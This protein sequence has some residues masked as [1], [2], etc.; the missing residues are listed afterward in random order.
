MRN[1]PNKILMSTILSLSM[2][3]SGAAAQVSSGGVYT[4]NQTAIAGGGG[5]SGDSPGSNYRVEGTAGQS[6]AGTVAGAGPYAVRNGFWI[7]NSLSPTVASVTVTGRVL[8]ADGRGIRGAMLAL[9]D[10]NGNVRQST[11]S[12]FGYYRFIDVSAGETYVLSIRAKRFQ[13]GQPVVVL[14]VVDELT[15]MDFVA[16]P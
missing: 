4:L 13:F 2:M 7:P 12:T 10:Q 9:T 6:T 11:S 5:T 8:T 15:G 3:A 1:I 14:S 16:A